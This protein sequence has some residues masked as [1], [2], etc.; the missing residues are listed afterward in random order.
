M[1][2]P[3]ARQKF[4]EVRQ[5]GPEWC[6]PAG[7]EVLL[8]YF[9]IPAPTQE[10]MVLEYDRLFGDKGYSVAGRGP[11]LFQNKP[12]I[13]DLRICGFPQGNFDT[14]ASI[15]NS[16]LAASC[17]RVFWHPSDCDP[18]FEGYLTDS[19]QLN[20]GLLTVIRLPTGNCHVLPLIGYDGKDVTVYD[21]GS[22]AVETKAA[23]TF[24]FN[25]DCVI[26][27]PK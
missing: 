1:E 2:L 7:Y 27:R 21:P 14:F 16:L 5:R 3:E 10:H 13:E 26:L 18:K 6:I 8:H 12:T 25:R 9:G 17:P 11:L 24:T 4:T 15:A 22:G 19:L 23:G 20:N